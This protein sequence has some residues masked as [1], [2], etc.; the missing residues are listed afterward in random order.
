MASCTQT[1]VIVIVEDPAIRRLVKSV[2]GRDGHQVLECG[3]EQA[4]RYVTAG[5]E[6]V[7]LLITNRP[8][9]FSELENT[10]PILYLTSTPDWDIA[11]RT[12][13]LRVLQ[14]PFHAKDLIEA[15]RDL[16]PDFR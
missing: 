6:P 1:G 5:E 16:A 9:E 4:L 15:V 10:V 2:L 11:R 12:R 14:K 8:Q 13:Q 3:A 7:K